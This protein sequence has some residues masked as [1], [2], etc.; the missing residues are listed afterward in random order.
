M[1]RLFTAALLVS[2]PA[3]A[4]TTLDKVPP[5]EGGESS[6]LLMRVVQYEGSINGAITIEVQNPSGAPQTFSAR[7]LYFVPQLNPNQAPQRL[8]VVGPFRVKGLIEW[9]EQ[10]DIA[11]GGSERLTLDVYCIDSHRHSP[12]QKTP[13]RV[14]KDRLP[15]TLTKAIDIAATQSAQPYG[16]VSAPAARAAVQGEVW[17]SRDAKW[18]KLDG[19]SKQEAGK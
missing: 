13:F 14:A 12:S 9:V 3:L 5:E 18:I 19:E 4:A 11:P 2:L 15:V 1:S 17:K 6:G 7:G 8:G 10:L 16:G